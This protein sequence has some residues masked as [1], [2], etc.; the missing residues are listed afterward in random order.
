MIITKN[1]YSD[2]QI[3]C[4]YF[5]SQGIRLFHDTSA[6]PQPPTNTEIHDICPS[7]N[8]DVF[9]NMLLG[10]RAAVLTRSTQFGIHLSPRI[11]Q[12]YPEQHPIAVA[13]TSALSGAYAKIRVFSFSN[14]DP[15]SLGSILFEIEKGKIAVITE[16]TDNSTER[17]VDIFFYGLYQDPTM[18]TERGATP[19]APRKAC[20]HGYTLRLGER[21]SVLRSPGD[22]TWGMVY[23]LTHKEIDKLYAGSGLAFYK[24]EPVVVKLEDGSDIPALCYVTLQPAHP[25][26]E[27][28]DYTKKL[29]TLMHELGL[30]TSQLIKTLTHVSLPL[31]G[32]N[33][34][35]APSTAIE[36]SIESAMKT[37]GLTRDQ[38]IWFL[39]QHPF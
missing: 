8:S 4:S 31:S 9:Y 5:E 36:S 13:G 17:T 12:E 37:W 32:I 10:Y 34:A 7:V 15:H 2:L 33:Q 19:R 38:A 26:A 3:L 28:P 14:S 18:L 29:S 30:P 11:R 24:A 6:A 27:N 22:I 39:N 16:G 35:A 1:F 20:L 25:D 21:G 23:S